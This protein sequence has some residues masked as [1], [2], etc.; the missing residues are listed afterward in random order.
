MRFLET[1]RLEKIVSSVVLFICSILIC[2]QS[3][4][5]YFSNKESSTDSSVF[6]YI[7]LEMS[8]GSVPYKDTFDHK[9][10]LL[11][12]LNYWG[13]LIDE[14]F[15]IWIIE[16][17]FCAVTCFFLFETARLFC[18]WKSA[19]F[20]VTLVLSLMGEFF[21]K[22]NLTEEYALP[23]IAVSI[24]F[25]SEYLLKN[26]L[27]K[28]NIFV[29][30]AAFAA[31]VM[32]RPNMI[33]VWIGFI[34]AVLL[35]E[36]SNKNWSRINTEI[37]YFVLGILTGS[38]PFI[39][40]LLKHDAFG[41][42]IETYFV[43]N[44]EYMVKYKYS[45]GSILKRVVTT[46]DYFVG[47]P[48]VYI[49]ILSYVLVGI[50]IAKENRDNKQNKNWLIL[51]NILSFIVTYVLLCMP[52][53]KTS[54]YAMV[55]IPILIF[56]ICMLLSFVSDKW[57]EKSGWIKAIVYFWLVTEIFY[58]NWLKIMN[59][60]EI[61]T[62]DQYEYQYV[63]DIID[64][65][66]EPDDKISVFGNCNIV[67]LKSGKLSASKYSY[68]FPPLYIDNNI[69]E[70]YKDDI[71]TEMPKII[72]I[73]EQDEK[74]VSDFVTYIGLLGYSEIAEHVYICS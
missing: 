41:D 46:F 39:F 45:I 26:E 61:G 42:F 43:F 50:K 56:P 22:G 19:L 73:W 52:G 8:K 69:Y 62:Q 21:T 60:M 30:G 37:L 15:G 6:Q 44:S 58:P 48:I 9:G 25:F 67:Y 28:C 1:K 14:H 23:F 11:Y 29:C 51:G 31:V 68:Q 47:R 53:S 34:I 40:Y 36:I 66:C 27:N 64:E 70:E 24:Y 72:Y 16:V 54:H 65:Y 18:N 35:K 13:L 5:N 49:A 3:P 10:P 12:F 7:A 4:L 33:A 2:M 17:F 55:M 74:Y 20:S 38:G 71:Q 57:N 32:L 63:L 59:N